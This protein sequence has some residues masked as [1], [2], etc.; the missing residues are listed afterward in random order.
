MKQKSF[1][2]KN[3]VY[4]KGVG[5]VEV[6]EDN[7]NDQSDNLKEEFKFPTD[8]ELEEIDPKELQELTKTIFS[9]PDLIKETPIKTIKI[10]GNSL[11]R[12]K[13]KTEVIEKGVNLAKAWS[14]YCDICEK[15]KIVYNPYIKFSSEVCGCMD[16][17]A[18]GGEK[19]KRLEKKALNDTGIMCSVTDEL[20]KGTTQQSYSVF[21]GLEMLQKKGVDVDLLEKMLLTE[22]VC[23]TAIIRVKQ[24]KEKN[25]SDY[26]FDVINFE[27]AE[28]KFDYSLSKIQEL[29]GVERNND[30]FDKYYCPSVVKR[31]LTKKIDALLLCQ[32]HKILMPNGEEVLSFGTNFILGDQ[33]LAKS[34]LATSGFCKYTESPIYSAGMSTR[35]GL[36]GGVQKGVS[37]KY[38]LSVGALPRQHFKGI[39]IDEYGKLPATDI[40]G[41][42]TIESEGRLDVQM[43][44]VSVQSDCFVNKICLGNLKYNV[45][46]YQTKHRASYDLALGQ[47]DISGKFSGADRRRKTHIV[48]IGNDDLQTREI[49]EKLLEK[50]DFVFDDVGFWRNLNQFAWSRKPE[51]ICWEVDSSFIMQ[52][53]LMLNDMFSDFELE[54]GILGKSGIQVFSKQLPA[55]AI[56]HGSLDG[57]LVVIK[58]EHV[59]WLSDLY[60]EELEALGLA[61]EKR[62]QNILKKHASLIIENASPEIIHILKLI[63]KYGSQSAVDKAGE[64][65]RQ[66]IYRNFKENVIKYNVVLKKTGER[67]EK[68][69]SFVDGSVVPLDHDGSYNSDGKIACFS[70]NDGTISYFGKLLL[71]ELKKE[72]EKDAL[73]ELE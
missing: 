54:Y 26:F 46:N 17:G 37:G 44:G 36:L 21:F 65:A 31:T 62:E 61:F 30:F 3:E 18:R 67:I 45:K 57:E 52:K 64:M 48:V 7:K 66:T 1:N 16:T 42:R 55:V 32:P 73:E 9:K 25:I 19:E 29:K 70:K 43:V 27:I 41:M 13:F 35:A 63:A 69:Y 10:F 12:I 20:D 15:E 71:E 47:H 4:V 60:F 2:K 38:V 33:G 6:E 58:E 49:A 28:K 5:L 14:V 53:V 8:E 50:R 11:V 56:L 59:N 40:A 72:Q 24:G 39:V 51:H 34:V 23:A 22:T 68:Y